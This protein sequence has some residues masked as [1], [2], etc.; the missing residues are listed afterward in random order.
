[1]VFGCYV[2]RRPF[3]GEGIHDYQNPYRHVIGFETCYIA[4][5]LQYFKI[6]LVLCTVTFLSFVR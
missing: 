2:I 3:D 6:S 4:S 1:M 5:L